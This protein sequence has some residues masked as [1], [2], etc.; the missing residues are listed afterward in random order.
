MITGVDWWQLLLH[1]SFQA[2]HFTVYDNG[3]AK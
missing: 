3:P 1:T 2:I